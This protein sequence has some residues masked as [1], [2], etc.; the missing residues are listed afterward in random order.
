MIN[1][2]KRLSS[3][4]KSYTGC[5]PERM[6]RIY[7]HSSDRKIFRLFS[8]GITYIGI[9]N[10]NLPENIAFVNF[11]KSFYKNG[12]PVPQIYSVSKDNKYYL[13]EDL[14]NNTLFS[15]ISG[16]NISSLKKMKFYKLVIKNLIKFQL[17]GCEIIDF[18]YCFQTKVF[19]EKLILTDYLKFKKYFLNNFLSINDIYLLNKLKSILLSLVTISDNNFFMYRDFQP[20]NIMVRDNKLFFIDF[21]TGRKGPLEYDLASFL[22]SGSISITEKG[23]IYLIDY[24]LKIINKKNP[25]K[26]DLFISNFYY[27]VLLRLIQVLGSYSYVYM[28][29]K[30]E[31]ILNKIPKALENLKNVLK[32]L[33]N[34][35]LINLYE[36]IASKYE[37]KYLFIP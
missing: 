37:S 19:N 10:N 36:L 35:D 1:K 23:I 20:R 27:F 5:T 11:C 15:I 24:Y 4:F 32:I 30:D 3:L 22:Y 28:K 13:E 12:F 26:K 14:G 21:Q 2:E 31:T 17:N 34:S 29:K 33:K 7:E 6:E 25:V 18:A 8:K 9:Y 16:R